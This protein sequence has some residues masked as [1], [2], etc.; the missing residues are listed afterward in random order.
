[1]YLHNVRLERVGHGP[2]RAHALVV[3]LVAHAHHPP[4]VLH[5]QLEMRRDYGMRKI[6]IFAVKSICLVKV[7]LHSPLERITVMSIYRFS[8]KMGIGEDN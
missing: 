3:L 6:S 8:G 4:V 2:Q 5:S 7:V 1:M